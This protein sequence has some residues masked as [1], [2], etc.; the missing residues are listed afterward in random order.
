[1]ASTA[2]G[3]KQEMPLIQGACGG[4]EAA[5]KEALYMPSGPA[6]VKLYPAPSSAHKVNV[7]TVGS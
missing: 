4:A 1:M 3:S 5:D 2:S 6:R 7:K